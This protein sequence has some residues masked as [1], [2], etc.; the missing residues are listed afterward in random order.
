M[1]AFAYNEINVTKNEICF[2][3]GS[4]KLLWE[5]E[6]MF[7]S[8]T[9]QKLELY[10]KELRNKLLQTKDNYISFLQLNGYPSF[11]VSLNIDLLHIKKL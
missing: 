6:K 1:K 11:L 9:R 4:S 8:Q 3:R 5:K 7:L 10:G 2:R